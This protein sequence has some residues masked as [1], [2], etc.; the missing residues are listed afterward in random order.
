MR[1][2]KVHRGAF[3]GFQPVTSEAGAEGLS[4][5]TL[6]SLEDG[7]THVEISLCSLD[8]GG[9]I[10]GHLHPFE[11]SFYVLSGEA[12]VSIDHDAHHLIRDDFGFA[13]VSAP[14]AW[15]N[16]FE[17][18]VTWYR[19]R[20]PQPRPV[21][22]FNGTYPIGE[23]PLPASGERV[24]ELHPRSR[25]LGHFDLSDMSPP[26]PLMMPGTHGHNIRDISVRMMVDDVLGAIHHQSFMVKF[27]PSEG[28]Y[29][30]GSAHY[31]DFEEAYFVVSGEG[32]VV[33]EGERFEMEAGELVWVAS[34]TMH[35][36]RSRGGEALRFI[37]LM[38]PRPPYMNM[39]F[40]EAIWREPVD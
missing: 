18:V 34:G 29:F 19:I 8:P 24:R 27:E 13:P 11:E 17:E 25:Y 31:H 22:R 6:V 3:A 1:K 39:L 33:L 5:S 23:Y 7:S 10:R 32:E 9:F 30:S 37:E 28:D 40:S 21:G 16:P 26:G 15:S 4:A 14:H 38:A 2:F 35:A 36:W 20:S 12:I